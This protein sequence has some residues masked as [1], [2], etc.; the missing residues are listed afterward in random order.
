MFSFYAML[1]SF[2]GFLKDIYLQR[3]KAIICKWFEKV[4][5]TPKELRAKYFDRNSLNCVL[6]E[7]MK[8]EGNFLQGMLNYCS[9]FKF[10]VA[11]HSL[12]S[13]LK[14]TKIIN[15]KDFFVTHVVHSDDYFSSIAYKDSRQL[16]VYE[17][18]KKVCFR[19]FNIADSEKKT[20]YT[21][22]CEFVSI[23][24]VN[25]KLFEPAFKKLKEVSMELTGHGYT[26]DM[27]AIMSR[28][29]E[30]VRYGIP[31]SICKFFSCVHFL[32]YGDCLSLMPGQRNHIKRKE[33]Q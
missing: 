28:V 12:D 33:I 6:P 14:E 32:H 10:V 26:E 3:L 13:Q 5:I 16:I 11:M 15:M 25:G 27:C 8:L 24:A 9:S 30:C 17:N 23:Y 18:L 20:C 2:K 1:N 29:G 22:L 7:E 21:E 31:H 19:Q 4:I